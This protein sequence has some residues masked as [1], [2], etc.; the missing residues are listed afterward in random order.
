MSSACICSIL[1]LK[2][3]NTLIQYL[4]VLCIKRFGRSG[5]LGYSLATTTSVFAVVKGS[6]RTRTLQMVA[7][8]TQLRYETV[9]K[10]VQDAAV[11]P[12]TKNCSRRSRVRALVSIWTTLKIQVEVKLTSLIS[13]ISFSVKNSIKNTQIPQISSHFCSIFCSCDKAYHKQ[14][15]C[16]VLY[17][18]GQIVT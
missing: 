12:R 8:A 6:R 5:L 2:Y 17:L 15:V 1:V 18:L 16:F 7:M 10:P 14:E 4:C 13:Y 3:N 9:H 11:A